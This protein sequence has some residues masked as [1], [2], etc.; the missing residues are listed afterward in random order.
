MKT[1]LSFGLAVNGYSTQ[2]K[3]DF[4]LAFLEFLCMTIKK[5]LKKSKDFFTFTKSQTISKENY[6]GLNS[7]KTKPNSLS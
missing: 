2:L 7:H 3:L 5:S 1:P 4:F 6:S